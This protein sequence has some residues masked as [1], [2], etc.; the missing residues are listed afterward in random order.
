M[1]L[2]SPPPDENAS[3]RVDAAILR[4]MLGQPQMPGDEIILAY[5]VYASGCHACGH[6]EAHSVE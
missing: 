6:G 5:T 3:V 2:K 4:Y 1:E